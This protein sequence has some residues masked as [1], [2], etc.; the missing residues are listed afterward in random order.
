MNDVLTN[1]RHDVDV[2][3]ARLAY[4]VHG[5]GPLVVALPGGPGFSHTYMRTPLLEERAKVVYLDPIGCGDSARL[6]NPS[7][8]GRA[9]DVADIEELR[10]HLGAERLALLGHS[11]GGFSRN[12]TRSNIPRTSSAWFS[13]TRARPMAPSPQSLDKEM[14][15]RS[16]KAWFPT[17]AARFKP[18]SRALSRR[19]RPMLSVMTCGRSM[20]T[21]T[22]LIPLSP[23][24]SPRSRKSTSS[25][26]RKR[27][28]SRSISGSTR[29][30]DI[31]TL[32]I[33]G[34]RDFICAPALA[35]L[36]HKAIPGSTLLTMS[37][38]GI[39]RTSNSRPNL[40]LPWQR[41]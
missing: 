11:A 24:A 36:L 19:L 25:A 27:R 29:S 2:N 20:R 16:S 9:R 15:A 33:V 41:F 21:T 35:K 30:L 4:H 13:T 34:A 12:C 3:G 22:R 31:P 40:Q 1:G 38:A 32:I 26:P 23:P 14:K 28:M 8:Y 10:K 37:E 5:E 6:A 39:C 18:S 17:A 7:Q